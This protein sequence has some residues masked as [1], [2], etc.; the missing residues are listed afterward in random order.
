MKLIENRLIELKSLIPND[1][2]EYYTT[3]LTDYVKT[4]LTDDTHVTIIRGLRDEYDL[5]YESKQIRFMQD[6]MPEVSVIEILC[7]K[8]FSHISSSSIRDIMKFESSQQTNPH[9]SSKYLKF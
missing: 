9:Y 7:D 1:R 3:F 2:V 4:K 6:M 8:E 5:M